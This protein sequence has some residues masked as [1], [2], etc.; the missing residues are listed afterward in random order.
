MR[1]PT[2]V[3]RFVIA[4]LHTLEPRALLS[5]CIGDE[6]DRFDLIDLEQWQLLR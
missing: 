2:F 5:I 6:V 3:A 1:L 4:L